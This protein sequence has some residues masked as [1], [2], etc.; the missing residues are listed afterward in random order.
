M[1]IRNGMIRLVRRFEIGSY[2]FRFSIGAVERPH[3]AYLAFNAAQLARKLGYERI[4]LIE[5][6]VAGGAGLLVLEEHARR[7]EQMFSIGIDVYGFDTGKG[8]PPPADY[9]DL[10][11][12]WK[13]GFFAMDQVALKSRLR[14][15]QLV[16]G[17][18]EETSRTFFENY[19]PAPIGAI[20]HDFDFYSSTHNALAM[21]RAG[22]EHFLPRVFFYFDDTIGSEVELYN[23]YTGERLAIREFN[24]LS[25][26]IKLCPPYHLL[27]KCP[28]TWHHQI[29]IGHFFHHPKYN[30]FVSAESQQLRL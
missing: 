12:H 6:G 13:E 4:S 23:D 11:Y 5:Y 28:E 10:P 24:E 17:D 20:I 7:V 14:K 18:I 3:Y 16:I 15:A 19:R 30:T 1:P 26:T 2:P 27:A 8:L 21:L 25:E 9:R 22:D 29:W